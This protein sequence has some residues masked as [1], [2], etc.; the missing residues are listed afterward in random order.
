MIKRIA[1]CIGL[2]GLAMSANTWAVTPHTLHTVTAQDG[3]WKGRLV[4]TSANENAYFTDANG[5]KIGEIYDFTLSSTKAPFKY[6]FGFASPADFNV[7]YVL[8][9]YQPDNNGG[10]TVMF[11]SKACQFNVSAK[12]P[13]DPDIRV[14][15]YNGAK[16]DYTVVPGVGENFTVS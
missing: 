6:G 4:I 2:F 16:C 13:A 1:F 9:L 8:T 14:E 10:N 11:A 12:G 5:N 3:V 7:S 15:P